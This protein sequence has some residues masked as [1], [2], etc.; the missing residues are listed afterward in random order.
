MP[1]V[2]IS[3]MVTPNAHCMTQQDFIRCIPTLKKS[4]LKFY[5]YHCLSCSD[6]HHITLYSKDSVCETLHRDPLYWHFGNPALPVIISTVDLFRQSKVRNADCH[7][8]TE[9]VTKQRSVREI[10][11]NFKVRTKYT[12]LN[13]TCSCELPGHGAESGGR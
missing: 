4:D 6:T 1:C 5:Q 2:A 7:I 8:I 10:A 3:H 12:H 13:P 11:L 9:P